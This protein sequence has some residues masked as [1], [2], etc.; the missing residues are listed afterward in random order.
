MVT[1]GAALPCHGSAAP[2]RAGAPPEHPSLSCP[3]P[4]AVQFCQMTQFAPIMMENF[5]ERQTWGGRRTAAAAM[6]MT[7]NPLLLPAGSH[8]DRC[9]TAHHSPRPPP[10]TSPPLPS[11][12]MNVYDIRKECEGALCY[13]EFEVLDRY[14]NQVG[15]AAACHGVLAALLRAGVGAGQGFERGAHA[16]LRS[17]MP[18]T[19]PH[20]SFYLPCAAQRAQGA[21]RGRP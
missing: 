19:Q 7:H 20:P 5:S 16:M 14:L 13:S 8:A 2:C 12:D 11:A 1:G 18:D 15:R 6:R 17:A 3:S 9:Q 10:T 4:A 21:G